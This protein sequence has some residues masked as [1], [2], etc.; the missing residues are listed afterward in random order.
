MKRTRGT[1]RRRRVAYKNR[2]LMK[3]TSG[4][5]SCKS[6][7]TEN[8][9]S[10]ASSDSKVLNSHALLSIPQGDNRDERERLTINLRGFR[11][12]AIFYNRILQPIMVNVAIISPLNANAPTLGGGGDFFTPPGEGIRGIPANNSLSGL[13]WMYNPINTDQYSVIWHTRFKL[14]V[15][16]TNGTP[17]FSSGELKN[18]RS[19]CRY[20]KCPKKINFQSSAITDATK[21]IFLVHWANPILETTGAGTASTYGYYL[22]ST[23][24]WRE[25]R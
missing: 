13:N 17:G 23:T 18:Y 4:R 22:H 12:R 10:P 8:P 19:L 21:P 20:I 15:I 11:L 3:I 1:S 7:A 5:N 25:P 9:T 16:A 24:Y 2:Q 14:G 6:R